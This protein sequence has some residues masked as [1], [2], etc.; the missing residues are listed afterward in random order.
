MQS[1]KIVR[2]FRDSG[3]SYTID[4]NMDLDDAKRWCSSPDASSATCTTKAGVRRTATKG[5][6]FDAYYP[7]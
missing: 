4:H 7:E 2:K 5:P 6:W 1:Y 3:R